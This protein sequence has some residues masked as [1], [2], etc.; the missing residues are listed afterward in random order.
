MSDS[1]FGSEKVIREH[2]SQADLCTYLV[3]FDL[4]ND[5]TKGYRL[6]PL[7]D[8]LLDAIVDFAFGLHEGTDTPNPLV[9]KKLLE[10]AKSI[11]KIPEFD[12]VR[13]LY[14][15]NDDSIVDDDI[16]KKYLKRG[17]FGELVLHLLLRDFHKTIPLL[18]K[19]HFKDAYSTT[20]HGFDAVHVHPEKKTLWLGEAKLYTDG[21]KGLKELVSDIKTHFVRDYLNDEFSIVSK[22]IKIDT[23]IDDKDYWLSLLDSKNKLS[24]VLNSVT[25]PLLC[26]YESENFSKHSDENAAEFIAAYESEV[27]DLKAYFDLKNDHPL[28]TNLN[29]VLLLFPVKNKK[30]LVKRLHEKLYAMQRI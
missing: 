5:G 30:D 23:S 14:C 29:I 9:R 28:K 15:D 11:Y 21:K 6:G 8:V 4:E 10:A 16:A 1:L 12:E 19:I 27:A 26:V 13:R 18:S 2:I 3:G 25:I 7:V 20:V 22:K 24:E 17:E